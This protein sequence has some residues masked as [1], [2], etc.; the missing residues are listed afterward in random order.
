MPKD[1]DAEEV[2]DEEDYGVVFTKVT[3]KGYSTVL[4]PETAATATDDLEAFQSCKLAYLL[5]ASTA[6]CSHDFCFA[7]AVSE[8]NSPPAAI[9]LK[10]EPRFVCN[11]C[12]KA[13]FHKVHAC[14]C[15]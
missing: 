6:S 14:L 7:E 10:S 11:C 13:H 5:Q 8:N 2:E 15:W 9:S 1:D 3:S 4:N 12:P